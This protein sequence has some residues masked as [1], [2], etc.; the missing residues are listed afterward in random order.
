MIYQNEAETLRIPNMGDAT[1]T[2]GVLL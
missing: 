2:I 1:S